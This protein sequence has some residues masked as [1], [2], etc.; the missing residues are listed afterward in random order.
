MTRAHRSAYANALGRVLKCPESTR[1][2]LMADCHTVPC[3]VLE[4][5][6]A[7]TEAA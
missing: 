4:R 1:D 2:R 5:L 3:A 6:D 7:L